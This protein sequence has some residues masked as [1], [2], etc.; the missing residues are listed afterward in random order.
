VALHDQLFRRL[1]D[2]FRL[3]LG[4]RAS[5]TTRR[6]RLVKGDKLFE[7]IVDGT[8]LLVRSTG[9]TLFKPTIKNLASPEAA[10]KAY[11]AA[12]ADARK[13]GFRPV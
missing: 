3:R 7:A 11:D 1:G 13:K 5:E 10:A 9:K 12:L 4:Q 8:Q 2:I 6:T